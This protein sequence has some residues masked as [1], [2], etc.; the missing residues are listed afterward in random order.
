M[1]DSKIFGHASINSE[2]IAERLRE[3]AFLLKDLTIELIDERI[4]YHEVFHF[5]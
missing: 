3:S 2:T 5:S 1:P 4:D